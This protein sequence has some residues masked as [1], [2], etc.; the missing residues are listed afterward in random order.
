MEQLTFGGNL[1]EV[2]Q[3]VGNRAYIKTFNNADDP[4]D[5]AP[6]TLIQAFSMVYSDGSWEMLTP[7]GV[8]HTFIIANPN[9]D[10]LW[11][12]IKDLIR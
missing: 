2:T 12:D 1:V 11:I 4:P 6:D 9:D 10:P 5:T 3:I 8:A 7:V